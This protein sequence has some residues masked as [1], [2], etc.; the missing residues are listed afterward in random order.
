[1]DIK[2]D[3][4]EY[5]SAMKKEILPFATTQIDLDSIMLKE[6]S[7]KEKGNYYMISLILGTLKTHTQTEIRLVIANVGGWG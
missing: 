2:D 3:I 5:C 1:M 6:I 4:M 7:Q